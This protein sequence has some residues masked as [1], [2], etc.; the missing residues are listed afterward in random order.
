[1][2]EQVGRWSVVPDGVRVVGGTDDPGLSAEVRALAAQLQLGD[3]VRWLGHRT[4]VADVR[5]ALDEVPA[6]PPVGAA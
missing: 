2:R 6:D 3:S 4:D 5:A 1:M